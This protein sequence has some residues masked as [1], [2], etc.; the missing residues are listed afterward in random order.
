MRDVIAWSYD[1][2]AEE[3]KALFRR[4]AVSPA[5]VPSPLLARFPRSTLTAKAP[6]LLAQ[7]TRSL[8]TWWT[9]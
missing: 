2:L 5:G 8:R 4:L 7:A 6:R 3:D 1:L 9:G